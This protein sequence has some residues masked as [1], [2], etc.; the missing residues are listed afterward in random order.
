MQTT[1]CFLEIEILP[2]LSQD[3]RT[4]LIGYRL[5]VFLPEITVM[6]FVERMYWDKEWSSRRKFTPGQI[7]LLSHASCR[8]QEEQGSG[9][10]SWIYRRLFRSA[11]NLGYLGHGKFSWPGIKL[12][13]TS[14]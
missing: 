2:D 4:N 11:S 3:A 9:H 8:R 13:P 10:Y 7:M 6:K 12:I 5:P 14:V 1:N